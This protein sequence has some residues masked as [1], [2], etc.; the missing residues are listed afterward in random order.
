MPTSSH[1]KIVNFSSVAGRSGRPTS[2]DYSATKWAAISITQSA[3]LAL[4]PYNI[5]VNAVCP[6][7]VPTPNVGLYRF[8]RRPAGRAGKL[9]S[10]CG[11]MSSAFPLKRAASTDD[12]AA[13]VSFLC[14]E[15]ADYVTGQAIN[16]DGGEEMN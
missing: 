3:A 15:D 13:V 4:A 7:T 12:I 16:V 2:A 10:G 5:N 9:E 8:N 1:G 6:G 11:D 14:S